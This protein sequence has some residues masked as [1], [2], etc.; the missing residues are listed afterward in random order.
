M[1]QK[2]DSSLLEVLLS[3]HDLPAS[4]IKDFH[5]DVIA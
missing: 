5:T 4:S 2:K 1:G 3:S